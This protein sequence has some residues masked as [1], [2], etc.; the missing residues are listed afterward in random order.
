MSNKDASHYWHGICS[1]SGDCTRHNLCA[2]F[3]GSNQLPGGKNIMTDQKSHMGYLQSLAPPEFKRELTQELTDAL[4]ELVACIEPTLP[5]TGDTLR[6][7]VIDEF[8]MGDID[9]AGRECHVQLRFSASARQGV[10]AA[11][12]IE[13][14]A[15]RAEA[16]IDDARRVSFRR[17][18]FN[19]DR[20]FVTHD[21][22]GGD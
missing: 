10:G 7:C 3:L 19:T 14:I 13:R 18:A 8:E 6:A 22:G 11:K 9:V 15:G 2:Q 21:L 1:A 16:V 4:P 20:S 17:V 5:T 12:K